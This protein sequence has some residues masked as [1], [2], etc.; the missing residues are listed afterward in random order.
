MWTLRIAAFVA[1]ITTITLN[2]LHGYKASTVFEYAVLFATFQAALDIS[3]CTLIG[4]AARAFAD[5]KLTVAVLALLMFPPLFANSVWNAVSQV[6]LVRDQGTASSV[7]DR[8]RLQRTDASHAR[9]TREL[10]TMQA[11]PTFQATAACALPKSNEAKAYCAN[12]ARTKADLDRIST[13]LGTT[14]SADPEPQ[15]SLVA[16]K[17]GWPAADVR[18][19]LAVFPVILAELVGSLGFYLANVANGAA[20]KASRTS[21][22]TRWR[23]GRAAPASDAKNASAALPEASAVRPATSAPAAPPPS[24]PRIIWPSSA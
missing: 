9:L 5:R 4:V 18:F 2:A 19:L 17:L 7:S 14:T 16:A 3:K 8:E 23:S 10:T 13:Q 22:W 24:A 15:V 1:A 11:S 21:L 20:P 12:V 6:V